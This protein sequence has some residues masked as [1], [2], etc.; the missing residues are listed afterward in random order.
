MRPNTRP[1]D[2]LITNS[3]QSTSLFQKTLT[4]LNGIFN[5]ELQTIE[6]ALDVTDT[7][8]GIMYLVDTTTA[9]RTINLPNLLNQ[10]KTKWVFAK[11]TGTNSLTLD[12]FSTQ[13]I[14]GSTTVVLSTHA[15][16][17]V[18][19]TRTEWKIIGA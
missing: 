5:G 18:M 6:T 15:Y 11:N 13:T 7:K 14:D 17:T 2:V 3:G 16:V 19:S 8:Y 9:S 12:G 1:T 4:F 10:T